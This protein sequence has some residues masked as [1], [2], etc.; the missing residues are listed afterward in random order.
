MYAEYRI[1]EYAIITELMDE[2]DSILNFSYIIF[3]ILSYLPFTNSSLFSIS[4]NFYSIS[5]K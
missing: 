2:K 5:N 4:I 1:W 3:Y